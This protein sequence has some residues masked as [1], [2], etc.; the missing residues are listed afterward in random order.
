MAIW[1]VGRKGLDGEKS[2]NLRARIRSALKYIF[3]PALTCSE[4]CIKSPTRKGRLKW[5][6][7]THT[8]HRRGFF[9]YQYWAYGQLWDTCSFPTWLYDVNDRDIMLIC[10]IV[11]NLFQNMSE[12]IL[13]QIAP[14]SRRGHWAARS[15]INKV[16][17]SNSPAHS[18][19]TFSTLNCYLFSILI[20]ICKHVSNLSRAL[21]YGKK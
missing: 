7:T 4:T 16:P 21:V 3:S 8:D 15:P 2:T 17:F 6:C 9:I 19:W 12:H 1:R 11:K 14:L 13:H 5:S 10:T 18:C 20:G